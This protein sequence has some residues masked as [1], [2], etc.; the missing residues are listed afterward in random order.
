MCCARLAFTTHGTPYEI[1]SQM[2]TTGHQ[3]QH[4][5]PACPPPIPRSPTS[6]IHRFHYYYKVYLQV[7]YCPSHPTPGAY[8][9]SLLISFSRHCGKVDAASN[10]PTLGQRSC[11][12]FAS[13]GRGRPSGCLGRAWQGISKCCTRYLCTM[14]YLDRVQSST[15]PSSNRLELVASYAVRLWSLDPKD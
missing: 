13:W 2:I 12:V 11:L 7:R 15:V 9:Y 10:S 6:Q 14:Q 8:V 3:V 4:A 5:L 1:K